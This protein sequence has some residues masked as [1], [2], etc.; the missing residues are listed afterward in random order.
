[1]RWRKVEEKREKNTSQTVTYSC[2]HVSPTLILRC[3]LLLFS[4][5]TYSDFQVSPTP[6]DAWRLPH[7]IAD[8]A[9]PLLLNEGVPYSAPTRHLLGTYSAPT[10]HLLGTYSNPD[11]IPNS[12]KSLFYSRFNTILASLLKLLSFYDLFLHIKDPLCHFSK[13]SD[14]KIVY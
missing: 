13:W 8:Q 11:S 9:C 10:R 2:F 12:E 14:P 3:H 4:G 5:V 6:K 7:Q 1:M